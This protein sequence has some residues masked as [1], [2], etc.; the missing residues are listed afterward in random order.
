VTDHG[1]Q[2][3]VEENRPRGSR[4]VIELPVIRPAD[5]MVPMGEPP[6]AAGETGQGAG[7]DEPDADKRPAGWGPG[8]RRGA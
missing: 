3:W 4:V 7:G 1:G 8:G 6:D 2:I 5:G